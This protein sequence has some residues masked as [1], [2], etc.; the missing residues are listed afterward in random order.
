M[1]KIN[2]LIRKDPRRKKSQFVINSL[3]QL[4]TS[5]IFLTFFF[6]NLWIAL[7]LNYYI[8]FGVFIYFIYKIVWVFTLLHGIFGVIC[9]IE[10]YVFDTICKNL[11]TNVCLL[12]FFKNFLI[13]S[14][15]FL[16]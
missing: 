8:D 14:V 12:L 15:F 5:V 16:W 11:A 4:T 7:Y 13:I 9:I 2:A 3:K 6:L 10:D 1:E